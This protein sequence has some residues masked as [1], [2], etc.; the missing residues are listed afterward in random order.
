[1]VDRQ[2]NCSL[3]PFVN[4]DTGLRPESVEK[5]TAR[6]RC[7]DGRLLFNHPFGAHLGDLLPF[8]F[9]RQVVAEPWASWMVARDPCRSAIRPAVE[10]GIAKSSEPDTIKTGQV[11]PS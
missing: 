10:G 6:F 5:T 4:H 3:L 8:G 2:V 9:E 1:M 7:S 11:T